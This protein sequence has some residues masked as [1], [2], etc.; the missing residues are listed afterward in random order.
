MKDKEDVPTK[1]RGLHTCAHWSELS[2]P[3]WDDRR[4]TNAVYITAESNIASAKRA[5][6][7]HQEKCSKAVGPCPDNCQIK[8]LL[9][10]LN[11]L[12]A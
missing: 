2:R 4:Q 3:W 6:K 1:F 11:R 12:P 5:A 9:E 10:E 8:Q 7:N